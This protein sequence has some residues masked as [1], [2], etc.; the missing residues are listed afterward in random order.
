MH[1]LVRGRQRRRQADSRFGMPEGAAAG[2]RACRVGEH[3]DPPGACRT[4]AASPSRGC[5]FYF[6]L[7]AILCEALRNQ[8][9]FG[10]RRKITICPDGRHVGAT[11]FDRTHRRNPWKD[12]RA[13]RGGS[14]SLRFT[15]SKG[16]SGYGTKD[17]W[18]DWSA[19]G[20]WGVGAHWGL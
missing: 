18:I 16:L 11:R 3:G 12:R 6:N 8:A 4:L 19:A 15:W 20:T 7:S 9:I 14:R 2:E 17:T 13:K 5:P 10:N 1:T